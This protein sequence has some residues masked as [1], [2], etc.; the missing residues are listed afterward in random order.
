MLGLLLNKLK[1]TENAIDSISANRYFDAN[2]FGSGTQNVDIAPGTTKTIKELVETYGT[3]E[4]N[5]V[6][7]GLNA[8]LRPYPQFDA[9]RRFSIRNQFHPLYLKCSGTLTVDGSIT[10]DNAG[11]A[12][13]YWDDYNQYSSLL[14]P[15]PI[16]QVFG[17]Y[18][19]S[20]STANYFKIINYAAN[21]SLFDFNLFMIG[22][23]GGGNHRYKTGSIF[24]S[25]HNEHS[26]N[27]GLSSGGG[28]WGNH[29]N[30]GGPGGGFLALYFNRLIIDGKEYGVDPE[31]DVTKISAN[32]TFYSHEPQTAGGAMVIAARTIIIGAN[33]TINSNGQGT[34]GRYSFINNL[35]QLAPYAQTGIR[36][37]PNTQLFEN[38]APIGNTYY[39]N[40]GTNNGIPNKSIEG[41]NGPE[42]GGAGIVLGFKI[43]G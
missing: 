22:G 19:Y 24:S 5:N 9:H 34:P 33:G 17:N 25:W 21:G 40:T 29:E 1:S 37:N 43:K 30:R 13:Y 38:G 26:R 11:S 27:C 36:W 15:V 16:Q 6:T 2:T 14:F 31:C 8:F 4:F 23:G 20:A 7:V 18:G 3:F 39:Y 41:Y 10:S 12:F 32:G 35:P 42:C 28:H